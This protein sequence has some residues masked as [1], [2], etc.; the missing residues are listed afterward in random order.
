MRAE[1]AWVFCQSLFLSGLERLSILKAKRKVYFN[2]NVTKP[3]FYGVFVVR[4]RSYSFIPRPLDKTLKMF[5]KLNLLTFFSFCA[6]MS[7]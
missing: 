5:Q 6:T 7:G 3:Q 2:I 1:A 4:V